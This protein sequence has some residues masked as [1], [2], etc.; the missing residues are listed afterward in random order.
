M[1]APFGDRLSANRRPVHPSRLLRPKTV[2][3]AS[4]GDLVVVPPI[5]EGRQRGV[6]NAE[7]G[8]KIA[9]AGV[10]RRK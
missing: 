3:K 5:G 7:S 4:G 9:S 6:H 10:T 8:W 2:N 1:V